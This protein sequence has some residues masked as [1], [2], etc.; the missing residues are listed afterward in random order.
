M[1]REKRPASVNIGIEID[2]AVVARWN[3]SCVPGVSIVKGDAVEVLMSL[4]LTVQDLVYMDPPY[5]TETRRQPKIYR[6][7]YSEADHQ[8]LLSCARSLPSMVLISGYRCPMYDRVLYD[9]QRHDF[10][11]ATQAGRRLESVWFNYELPARLHDPRFL[12]RTFRERQD[13]RRRTARLKQRVSTLPV[14]E[15]CVLL[16]WLSRELASHEQTEEFCA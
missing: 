10:L 9:W 5:V 6:H 15:Q 8:R 7:E 14:A 3:E 11:S 13:V 1:L 16:D 4:D 12:G 2:P